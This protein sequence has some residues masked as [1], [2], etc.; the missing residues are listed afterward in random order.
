MRQVILF[1]VLICFIAPASN[2]HANSLSQQSSPDAAKAA[3]LAIQV[4]ELYRQAK[5][6]EALPL[7]KSCLEIREKLFTAKD[8]QFRTALKNLAEVYMGLDQHQKARPLFERLIKAYE[9]FAPLDL[10]LAGELRRLAL[11]NFIDGDRKTAERLLL[12][13]IN[14]TEQALGPESTKVA[15]ASAYLAEYYQAVGDYKKAEPVYQRI[16]SIREKQ[17]S[18]E[19]RG[20]LQVVLERYACLLHKTEREEKALELERRATG[21]SLNSAQTVTGDSIV[22]GIINGK[23]LSLPR[24]TYPEEAR[25]VGTG[26]TV[27]VRVVIDEQG[28]V[29]R[30]CAV[31]GPTILMRASEASAYRALFSPTKLSGQPVKV[32]GIIT[33]NFVAR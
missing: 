30:A 7:A 21:V 14:L 27:I 8:E 25:A 22:A 6:A 2:V 3:E 10:R 1:S 18:G 4:A 29:I 26:G 5:Y 13:T 9:A 20:D 33:Y 15:D 11:I 32:T 12:R 16:L 31:K 19:G 17:A 24:P 23:A 28:K